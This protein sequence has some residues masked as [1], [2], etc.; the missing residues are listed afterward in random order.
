MS[1]CGVVRHIFR[2]H[3]FATFSCG[4]DHVEAVVV[5][6]EHHR[7]AEIRLAVDILP[8]YKERAVF[9]PCLEILRCSHH[10]SLAISRNI[11]M[12]GVTCVK[13]V[14]GLVCFVVK[15]R[16]GAE[17]ASCSYSPPVGMSSP[18]DT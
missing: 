11:G 13:C 3:A 12:I 4:N 9:D 1:S 2:Q 18:N 6:S 7:V 5:T 10:H 14:I 17:A 15:H 16:T 8:F